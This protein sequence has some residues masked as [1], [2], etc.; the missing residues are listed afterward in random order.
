MVSVHDTASTL[1]RF[2]IA[3]MTLFPFLI[4]LHII[5]GFSAKENWRAK[6]GVGREKAN[7]ESGASGGER[8]AG[9]AVGPPHTGQ[10]GPSIALAR[11]PHTWPSLPGPALKL[12]TAPPSLA[13]LCRPC[14]LQGR[15]RPSNGDQ[16]RLSP[17]SGPQ[18]RVG[19]P[20]LAAAVAACRRRCRSRC[21]M[22]DHGIAAA[23]MANIGHIALHRTFG[24]ASAAPCCLKHAGPALGWPREMGSSRPCGMDALPDELLSSILALLPDDQD[25]FLDMEGDFGGV[26][27]SSR[28][29]A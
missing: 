28:Q 25:V 5:S 29:A 17:D 1:P 2:Y 10:R 14:A 27:V 20:P 16:S 22:L 3:S 9:G 23:G 24:N 18:G 12:R 6:W 8:P 11:P 7:Y 21:G 15:P 13:R 4:F 19:S 26:K